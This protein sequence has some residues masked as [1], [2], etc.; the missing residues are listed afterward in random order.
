M[1]NYKS[2]YCIISFAVR[3]KYINDVNALFYENMELSFLLKKHLQ[4]TAGNCFS[5][6]GD[7]HHNPP[8]PFC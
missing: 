3:N 6:A 7:G 1:S 5:G 4:G 2:V 8:Q